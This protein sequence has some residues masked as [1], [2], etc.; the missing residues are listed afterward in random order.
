MWKE[1]RLVLLKF[2]DKTVH[3]PVEVRI[4]TNLARVAPRQLLDRFWQQCHIGHMRM[5]N[6][7]WDDEPFVVQSLFDLN[8]DQIRWI[9]QPRSAVAVGN[10]SPRR[11]DEHEYNIT[12]L[13]LLGNV[14]FKIHAHRDRIHILEY[15]G[16]AKV[17]LEAITD[18]SANVGRVAT[19]IGN[20]DADARPPRLVIVQAWRR[21]C[22]AHDG[23]LWAGRSG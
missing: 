1:L 19:A 4:G 22:C 18:A 2:T 15:V 21:D 8:S 12:L 17:G 7:R 13:Q 5:P 23:N 3:I 14:F 10:R 20:K 9:M 16:G 6:Q 11:P